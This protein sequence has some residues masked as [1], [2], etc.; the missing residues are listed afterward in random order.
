MAAAV[1]WLVQLSSRHAWPVILSFLLLAT[2]S[3]SYFTRHFAITTDSKK[4]LSSSL[5]WREQERMLDAA[6]PHRTDRIIAVIDAT[7]P[8]AADDAADALTRGL[9]SKPDVIRAVS[10][11]DGGEFFA[12]D[13]ILLL[14]LDDV[15]RTTADLISAQPF[16]GTLSA[17]PT[18]RGVFRTLS[19]S[20]EGVRL[21]KAKLEDL[22]PA[23]ASVADALELLA[24]GRNPAFSWRTLIAGRPPK[25]SELRR[26]VNIEPVLDFG[27]LQPGRK[28][29][30]VIRDAASRLGLTPEQGVK[31]RLTGPVALSD[32]EF[33][34]VADG[35]VLN[36]VITLLL[37]GLVLWLALR[38]ARIILAVFVNLVFGLLYTAA[39]GLWMVGAFNL[40]SVAFAVLFVGLGVDFGIQFCVRYRAEQHACSDL[41]RALAATARGMAGPLVLAAV[42][43]A[44]AFYSFLPTAYRGLSELGLISGIGIVI[45]LATTLTLLPALLTVLKPPPEQHPVGYAALAPLDRFLEKRRNWIVGTTLAVA[46][47][48]LPLLAGLRFDFNPLD[49]RAQNSESV[50]TLLDL[51]NVPETSPNTLDVLRSNVAQAAAT[52]EKL[53]QLPEVGRVLTLQSFVPKDQDAKLALIEDASFFF[54]NTLSPDEIDADS[55]PAQMA[56]VINSLVQDLSAAAGSLD[57]PAAAQA[58]RLAGVLAPLATAP[59]A[60]M[61][62]ARHALV[63]PLSATLRQTRQLL[64]AEPVSIETLPSA[65]KQAWISSDGLAR[66]ELAPK[67]EANDNT[68]LRRFVTA[69]RAVTPD[70]AGSP[71][72]VIEAASSVITAFLQAG[73]LSVVA[74]AL[75]LFVALRRWI[76]VALTLVPLLV[77]IVVTLEICV[78]IGLQLNFAN[79]IA[80]PLLLGVG[81]AFKI[82]YIIAWRSGETRFLQSSLTRAV[83]YSA[84]TTAIAFGS[85]CFSHHPGTSSMGKLMALSLLTTLSAAVIFQPAL[86]AT[87]QQRRRDT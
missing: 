61:D 33:A 11:P 34:S 16:L 82:Y 38:K 70:A 51:M 18:L 67:P 58:R 43:I 80:L 22:R 14:G 74:I 13:G 71:V 35:A 21:G 39:I 59:V 69:V 75:I 36:G 25:P 40:I 7:T 23:F 30:A 48:G 53:R 56:D 52:A 29:T 66:I 50:A 28:A 47:L 54:Q 44:T 17:D 8:E 55:T 26:F 76:D 81:V 41:D 1:T 31:V 10:R 83:F 12:R 77:A 87:Q 72:F 86:L 73:I 20:L 42:S 32:E 24:K 19:Q 64:A 46:A 37:V 62:K 63:A 49:L 27:D 15:Q 6:F 3:A 68:S 57:S 5:P 2:L 9:A 45:A 85:L 60:A 84:C 79:I 78:L 65:L 4:L